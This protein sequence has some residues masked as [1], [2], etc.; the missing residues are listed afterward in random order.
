MIEYQLLCSNDHEFEAWFLNSA[1]YEVQARDGD[2]VCPYCGDTKVSKA[3]MAPRIQSKRSGPSDADLGRAENRVREVAERI[4]E[5]VGE[6]RRHVETNCE[7]VGDGFADEARRIHY[8]E[9][10]ERGIYGRASDE[11]AEALD[12]EGIEFYRLPQGRRNS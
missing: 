2:V 7:D 5:A 1:T 8:G 11:E 4:L 10:E 3:I 6:I 9:A 12:E